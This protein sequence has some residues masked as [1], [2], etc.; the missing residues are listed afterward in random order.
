MLRDPDKRARYDRFGIEGLRGVGGGGGGGFDD[1]GFGGIGDLFDA[2]FGG[3]FGGR[4]RG[5]AG[6]IRGADIEAVLDLEFETAVFGGSHDLGIDLPLPCA[7]CEGSGAR[8][9]TSATRCSGC[10]GTGEVRRVR[11]S[12]LGQMVTASPCGRCGGLG[13]EITSPCPDCRGDGRRVESPDIDDRRSRRHRRGS[14][15][16]SHRSRVGGPRGGPPGDLYVHIRVRRHA[17]FARDGDDL[18]EVL[19]VA[20]TQAVLGARIEYQTLDGAE[21]L[22]IPPGTQSG[23]VL[24]LRGRGVPHVGGRGRGDLVVQVAVDTPTELTPAQEELVRRLAVER[25]EEVAPP[26]TGFL[27]R[28]RSAFK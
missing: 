1:L 13:E 16:A 7:T 25:G 26:E 3:G 14:D 2:F 15:L 24:K 18:I 6:P 21:T 10:E 5:P 23:R 9:G 8:P 4:R 20:F 19:H 17:R 28:I 12:I 11:Q 22:V 27:G